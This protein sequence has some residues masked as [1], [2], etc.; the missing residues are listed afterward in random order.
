MDAL[1]LPTSSERGK[2][3][4]SPTAPTTPLLPP[5]CEPWSRPTVRSEH[6]LAIYRIA[7]RVAVGCGRR[8]LERLLAA[9]LASGRSSRARMSPPSASATPVTARTIICLAKGCMTV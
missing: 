5:N 1:P 6:R 8:G 4:R 9:R 2:R 7:S 3:S